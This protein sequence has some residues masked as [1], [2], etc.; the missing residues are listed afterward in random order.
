MFII[1]YSVLLGPIMR[2][3]KAIKKK[4]IDLSQDKDTH[5]QI[6]KAN[7]HCY[8]RGSGFDHTTF[9]NPIGSDPSNAELCPSHRNWIPMSTIIQNHNELQPPTPKYHLPQL[10]LEIPHKHCP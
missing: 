6:Y 7:S 2:K 10:Q 3:Q 1:L 8:L 4:L 9:K 5:F